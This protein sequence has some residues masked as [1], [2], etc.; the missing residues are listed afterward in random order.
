[1]G[2]LTIEKGPDEGIATASIEGTSL[3]VTPVA[4]G[5]TNLTLKESNGGKTAADTN[6]C[7]S[8]QV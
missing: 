1:M 4:A 7:I 6:K 5:N 8:R 3:T 2:T